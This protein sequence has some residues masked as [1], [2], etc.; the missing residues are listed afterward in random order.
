MMPITTNNSTNVKPLELHRFMV[1][2]SDQVFSVC[3][4]R[5][6]K[7]CTAS[8]RRRRRR[9]I[10]SATTPPR[11][12]ILAPGSGRRQCPGRRHLHPPPRIRDMASTARN[13][14][15]EIPRAAKYPL[16]L[17]LLVFADELH[18][19]EVYGE[20][21]WVGRP[22]AN[23]EFPCLGRIEI[24]FVAAQVCQWD[25]NMNPLPAIEVSLGI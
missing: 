8:A 16:F 18:H 14:H 4:F 25:R 3:R 10:N 13:V 2:A 7:L 12:S 23:I 24:H 11:T 20:I 17:S 22:F 1:M 21:H 19:V 15:M 5:P 6:A 9:P